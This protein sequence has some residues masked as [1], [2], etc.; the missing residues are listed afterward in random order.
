MGPGGAAPPALRP[1][2][3]THCSTTTAATARA[4]EARHVHPRLPGVRRRGGARR[5]H[6]PPLRGQHP[7]EA[8][9]D[10][11]AR[12]PS[13][14][15]SV[16]MHDFTRRPTPGPPARPPRHLGGGRQ[17][18]PPRR[19]RCHS[20]TP[21]RTATLPRCP[22]GHWVQWEN[23]PTCSTPSPR[24]SSAERQNPMSTPSLPPRTA[25]RSA[26]STWATWW[27]SPS[28]SPT[29]G[30]SAPTSIGPHVDELTADVLR[31]RLDDRECRFLIQRGPSE[32]LTA[33]GWHVDDHETF[34]R[35]VKRVTE[36]GLQWRRARSRRRRVRGVER[37]G[38][39]PAL[40]GITQ[41]IFTTPLRTPKPTAHAHQRGF[42]TGDAGM[43]HVAI[44]TR[45]PDGLHAYFN[46]V[47]DSRLSDYIDEN[48]GG[49]NLKIRFLRVNERHHSIAVANAA[50][51]GR[52]DRGT[53]AQHVNIQA[54]HALDDML[55][56]HQRVRA[57]PPDGVVRGPAHQR[58]VPVLLL[59]DAVGLRAGDGL[60]SGHGRSGAGGHRG[61]PRPTRAS[62]SGATHPS[63]RPS[64]PSSSSSPTSCATPATPRIPVPEQT[65]AVR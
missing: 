9:A 22:T 11:T 35:I 42:V 13:P 49:L 27:R 48:V 57:R 53:C 31:F 50:A 39:S 58:Q 12:R 51:Q 34:D 41:E 32:D 60:E 20:P 1:R 43:G 17:G 4:G 63:V 46:T 16:A 30:A 25:D 14:A 18:E 44:T 38:G 10:P 15:A 23:A 33:M 64:S 8:V 54:S 26:R 24:T 61:H 45:D 19:R 52:P 40:L 7:A 6:R 28:T 56:A 36:R 37:P 62:A 5:A 21:C 55:S 59:R 47:F 3:S 65:G 2:A 29:G